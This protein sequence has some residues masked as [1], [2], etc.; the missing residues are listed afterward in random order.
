M[1]LQRYIH[2]WFRFSNKFP[3]FASSLAIMKY[4]LVILFTIPLLYACGEPEIDL[5]DINGINQAISRNPRDTAALYARA[6]YFLERRQTDSALLDMKS[7]IDIDTTKASYY[8]TL[9]DIYLYTNRTRYSREAFE[10]AVAIAPGSVEAHMKLA[11][12]YLYVEMYKESIRELN[13]VL[14]IDKHNPKAYYMKGV[15]YK[16]TGDTALSISSFLTTT[17]QDAEY[18]HAFEQLG[19]IYAARQDTRA[20]DFYRNALRINPKNS[21][22]T[23][24]IGRFYQDLKE[25]DKAIQT[26]RELV[27]LDPTYSNAYYN[28]GYIIFEV[29]DKPG[30]ALPYFEKAVEANPSYA[31][32]HYMKGLCRE[33]LGDIQAAI[34]DY[35]LS[36]ELA[37][38]FDLPKM[39]L[40][41]LESNK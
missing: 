25:W 28:I 5:S 8:I 21:L 35:K 6:K 22:V 33:R 37:P 19:L 13:E 23:Y 17:E 20:L 18:A 27:A 31:Q 41:R 38:G 2:L 24:N 15:I 3:Y 9:G 11:E 30:E 12:L 36:A 14:R 34:A 39:G 40:A 7:L 29:N 32:A 10:R 16:E 26:Y 1:K 4:I